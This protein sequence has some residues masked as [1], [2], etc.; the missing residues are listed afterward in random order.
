MIKEIGDR[1]ASGSPDRN[2]SDEP[3]GS[4]YSQFIRKSTEEIE[5]IIR[6]IQFESGKKSSAE[7]PPQPPRINKS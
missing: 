6:R 5:N 2:I 4:A 3:S 1:G 7:K